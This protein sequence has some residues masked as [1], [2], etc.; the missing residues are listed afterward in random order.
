MKFLQIDRMVVD[1]C[2]KHLRG[3]CG[4]SMDEMSGPHHEVKKKIYEI[5]SK[6]SNS[7]FKI[8]ISDCFPLLEK[9][10]KEGRRFDYIFSDL[11]DVPLTSEGAKKHRNSNSSFS[12]FISFS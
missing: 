11:T 10:V 3:A 1:L 6:F 7:I 2:K 9:Y 5:I 8:I 12:H 4:S